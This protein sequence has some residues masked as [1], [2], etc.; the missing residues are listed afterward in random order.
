MA[1]IDTK[2]KIMDAAESLFATHGFG[3]VS[4]RTIIKQAKVNTAAVHYHFGSKDGLIEAVLQRRAAPINQERL[5]RLDAI[6]SRH[7]SGP[8]PLD[9]VME[10]FLAPV[11]RIRRSPPA[12]SR[13]LS[14]L[15]G[16]A[17]TEPGHGVKGS[18]RSVFSEIFERFSRAF[19]R[20]LPELDPE[21]V[22][23]RMYFVVGALAFTVAGPHVEDDD[24]ASINDQDAHRTLENLMQFAIAGL[25]ATGTRND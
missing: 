4:L 15:L 9:D 5:E 16:R 13:L 14:Q 11:I 2:T 19:V 24:T 6:E 25:R 22:I 20:A 12:E 18:M 23:R 21:D 7:G 17:I 3:A 8:L 1:D 10:A